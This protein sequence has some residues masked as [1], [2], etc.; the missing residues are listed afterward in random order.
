MIKLYPLK[1]KKIKNIISRG[2][3]TDEIADVKYLIFRTRYLQLMNRFG[4]CY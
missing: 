1:D 3:T 4:T 2:I